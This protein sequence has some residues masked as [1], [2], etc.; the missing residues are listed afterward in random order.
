MNVL[1]RWWQS[2]DLRGLWAATV[3]V[4]IFA[5]A[6]TMPLTPHDL[7]FHVR[8]GEQMIEQRALVTT[9]IFSYTQYG[10]AYFNNAWLGE[11]ALYAAWVVG[12]LPLLVFMRAL[13]VLCFYAMFLWLAWRAS[14]SERWSAWFVLLAALASYPHWQ[15]RPQTFALPIFTLFVVILMRYQERGRAPLQWLALLMIAWVN[16]HGS[17]VFGLLLVVMTIAGDILERALPAMN[18]PMLSRPQLIRLGVWAFLTFAAMFVNPLGIGILDAVSEI[19]RDPSIQGWVLE[20]LPANAREFPAN[21]FYL[22]VLAFLIGALFSRVRLRA[23]PAL[24]SVTF[25]W[26]GWSAYRNALWACG[27]VVPLLSMLWADIGEQVKMHLSALVAGRCMQFLFRPRRFRLMRVLILS[28]LMGFS[29]IALPM[30]RAAFVGDD[31]HWWAST[32]T[33][34]DAVNY[35]RANGLRGRTYHEIG[36]GSY[37]MWALWPQQQVFVDSRIN[38]YPAEQWR[39]YFTVTNGQDGFEEI[40]EK[41]Q[42]DYLLVNTFWQPQLLSA[43]EKRSARWQLL[44]HCGESFLFGRV[45]GA[46][47]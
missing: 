45:A 10:K 38:L 28:G 16:L 24:W 26:L 44:C 27:L 2:D 46:A 4:L 15:L 47:Q 21:V 34:I 19:G 6:A 43:V 32:D 42:V 29:I 20:W 39:D 31:L 30:F 5:V 11:L 13:S 25:I 14:G 33:P 12:G 1:M 35:I 36:A 18:L 7:W 9:D 22:M 3:C 40:L 8:L 41:Y 23:A 37:L 17:F